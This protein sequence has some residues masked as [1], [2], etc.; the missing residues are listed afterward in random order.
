MNKSP[1][2]IGSFREVQIVNGQVVKNVELVEQVGPKK[3][4]IYLFPL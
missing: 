3:E 2:V 4:V 1:V